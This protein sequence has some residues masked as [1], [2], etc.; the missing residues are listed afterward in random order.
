MR[1]GKRRRI[2]CAQFPTQLRLLAIAEIF[3]A[4]KKEENHPSAAPCGLDNMLKFFIAKVTF[5]IT[6]ET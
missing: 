6:E 3:P 1:R 4:A 5:V 2:K